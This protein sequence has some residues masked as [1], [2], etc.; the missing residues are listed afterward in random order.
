MCIIEIVFGTVA[1]AI[2]VAVTSVGLALG[3]IGVAL[4]PALVVAFGAVVAALGFAVGVVKYT[5]IVTLLALGFALLVAAGI[6]CIPLALPAIG[7]SACTDYDVKRGDKLKKHK[8]TI[9]NKVKEKMS[10]A[11]KKISPHLTVSCSYTYYSSKT[12]AAKENDNDV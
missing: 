5:L 10:S 3:A 9:V 8:K 7:I 6:V 11:K 4:A 12:Y 1:A 2:G